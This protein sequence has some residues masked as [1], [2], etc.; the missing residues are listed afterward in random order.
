[1]MINL[2]ASVESSLNGLL[3]FFLSTIMVIPIVLSA[4][5]SYYLLIQH[6]NITD[7]KKRR[8]FWLDGVFFFLTFFLLGL[9]IIFIIKSWQPGVIIWIF[10]II[11]TLL[12]NYRLRAL[13]KRDLTL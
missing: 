3:I 2:H 4:A 13:L 6:Q 11:A 9:S 10:G 8:L 5:V 7:E 12:K 1:M